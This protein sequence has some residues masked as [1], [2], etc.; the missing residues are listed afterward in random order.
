ME[1]GRRHEVAAA[2]FEM[3]H[4]TASRI[5][6]DDVLSP[7]T[8]MVSSRSLLEDTVSVAELG[9]MHYCVLG[10][11]LPTSLS[12]GAHSMSYRFRG[13]EETFD[14]ARK[15]GRL[16][17]SFNESLSWW[18]WRCDLGGM[19]SL[20]ATL[21]LFGGGDTAWAFVLFRWLLA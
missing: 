7:V 4:A 17:G 1:L 12:L 16:G 10:S 21:L 9:G 8:R 3:A 5:W 11:R 18:V 15:A 2:D 13:G 14:F 20:W 19:W 6:R